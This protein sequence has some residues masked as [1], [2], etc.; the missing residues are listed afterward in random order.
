MYGKATEFVINKKCEISRKILEKSW[1][2]RQ[3]TLSN[4][5]YLTILM[6]Q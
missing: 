2:L 4:V 1:Y 5:Y 3:Q 6:L